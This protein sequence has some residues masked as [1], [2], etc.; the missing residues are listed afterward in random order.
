MIAISYVSE[1]SFEFGSISG[2]VI[3]DNDVREMPR[4]F[5]ERDISTLQPCA[6]KS[7]AFVSLGSFVIS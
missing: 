7:I 2:T 5:A 6:L 4:S 1:T 3:S